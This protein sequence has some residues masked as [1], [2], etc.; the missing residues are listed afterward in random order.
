MST[1]PPPPNSWVGIKSTLKRAQDRKYDQLN[2]KST[3]CKHRL[4]CDVQST[5]QEGNNSTS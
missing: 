2:L 1:Q 4:N 5:E 3:K